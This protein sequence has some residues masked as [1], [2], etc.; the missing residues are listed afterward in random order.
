MKQAASWIVFIALTFSYGC[1]LS[2]RQKAS[3]AEF[4]SAS[5]D[6]ANIAGEA[7]VRTRA[8]VIEMNKARVALGDRDLDASK[9]DEH[10]TIER[11]EARMAAVNALNEYAQLLLALVN[12]SS[13]ERLTAAADSFLTSLRKIEGAQVSADQGKAF[14]ALVRLG[15]G[16]IVEAKRRKSV[17]EVVEFAHPRVLM[18]VTLVERDF[19]PDADHWS[20]GYDKVAVALSGQAKLVATRHA[21]TAPTTLPANTAVQIDAIQLRL[22][23]DRNR[24]TFLELAERVLAVAAEVRR[25]QT[26]LRS[27]VHADTIGVEDIHQYLS[28]V[29]ELVTYY[30]MLK[31]E[32]E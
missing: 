1:G 23:A 12:F 6:F 7:L 15:G 3:V 21:T 10:F 16:L 25:A 5:A 28:K 22:L 8:E 13:D 29:Q 17:Q 24:A 18:I 26:N 14:S 9:L 31:A 20:L 4:G 30:R 11:V 2:T 27:V 19:D 32:K